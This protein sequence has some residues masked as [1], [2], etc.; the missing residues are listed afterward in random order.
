MIFVV[1]VF[2]S[3]LLLI[4]LVLSTGLLAASIFV[5]ATGTQVLYPP[6]QLFSHAII[7][8]LALVAGYIFNVSH[9]KG[10]KRQGQEKAQFLKALGGSIAHEIRNP[11]NIISLANQDIQQHL[12]QYPHARAEVQEAIIKHIRTIDGVI[13]NSTGMTTLLLGSMHGKEL[14]TSDFVILSAAEEIQRLLDI[15]PFQAG[16]AERVSIQIKHDFCFAGSQMLFQY[17]LFN[18]LKNAIYYFGQKASARISITITPTGVIYFRDTGVGIAADKIDQLFQD[19]MT[20]DKVGGTGLG[21]SFCKRAMAAMQGN[22]VCQ[23]ELGNYT[24]FRL[25]FPV[26]DAQPQIKAEKIAQSNDTI[27]LSKARRVLIIED[28]PMAA[29]ILKRQLS[30]IEQLSIEIAAD[31]AAAIAAIT[32]Q[33]PDMIL[34]DLNLP[35]VAGKAWMAQLM[36]AFTSTKPIII[37]ISGDEVEPE[38]A[39]QLD[40]AVLKPIKRDDLFE[41]I[42]RFFR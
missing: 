29:N 26:V 19:F 38:I 18:L 21:L 32:A 39:A 1:I 30:K 42:R 35:D 6:E 15:Y 4:L 8:L 31:G 27:T 25:G 36:A 14:D 10:L 2:T 16:E 37:G 23:S 7:Y 20:A 9:V 34:T 13:S 24:E 3:R 11:L 22:I 33:M 5:L 40:V 41:L 12:K 28:E 17:I